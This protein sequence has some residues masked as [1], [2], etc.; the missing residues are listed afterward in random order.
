MTDKKYDIL[1]IDPRDHDRPIYVVIE[2]LLPDVAPGNAGD[3]WEHDYDVVG[4]P[5]RIFRNFHMI[6][7]DGEIDGQMFEYLRTIDEPAFMSPP[8]GYDGP[9]WSYSVDKWKA[10]IPEAFKD[11]HK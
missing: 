11:D 10:I 9:P 1:K 3:T 6:V 7:V 5:D 4:A 2:S 8:P